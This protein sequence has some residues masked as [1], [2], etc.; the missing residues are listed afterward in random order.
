MV[1]RRGGVTPRTGITVPIPIAT[2]GDIEWRP[3]T[4]RGTVFGEGAE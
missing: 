1:E 4:I 3:P 2:T